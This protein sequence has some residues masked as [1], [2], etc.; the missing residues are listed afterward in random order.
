MV[1]TIFNQ[2]NVRVIS[3]SGEIDYCHCAN[4]EI[5]LEGCTSCDCLILE[6]DPSFFDSEAFKVLLKKV[7]KLRELCSG[8]MAIVAKSNSVRKV[9]TLFP[10]YI[11]SLAIYDSR[12]EALA[13]LRLDMV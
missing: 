13:A 12:E 3:F 6:L 10:Q 11:R 4:F 8:R 2:E 9:F 7:D 5:V 1:Y